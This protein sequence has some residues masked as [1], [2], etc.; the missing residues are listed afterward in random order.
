MEEEKVIFTI[1]A[2]KRFI[3]ATKAAIKELK[4]GIDIVDVT[5]DFGDE[6]FETIDNC[7]ACIHFSTFLDRSMLETTGSIASCLGALFRT[8]HKQTL[9]I[10]V[11]LRSERAENTKRI[12]RKVDFDGDDVLL[13]IAEDTHSKYYSY[14][15]FNCT[16][17]EGEL[18][19]DLD[20]EDFAD[21]IV[22]LI[23][24]RIR[25]DTVFI[26]EVDIPEE[27]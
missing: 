10:D 1:G 27:D 16:D 20:F 25:K 14:S 8:L 5:P 4:L 3:K 19:D 13:W 23:T 11:S 22:D 17:D 24:G 26:H 7:I 18:N 9:F 2:P 21:E 6:V 15:L 12:V